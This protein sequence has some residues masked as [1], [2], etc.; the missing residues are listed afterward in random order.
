ML[1]KTKFYRCFVNIDIYFLI[2]LTASPT[3]FLPLSSLLLPT[4]LLL[5]L[6]LFH[7]LLSPL[8]FRP[9]YIHRSSLLLSAYRPLP[10]LCLS[11]I[12]FSSTFIYFFLFLLTTAKLSQCRWWNLS[13]I[14]LFHWNIKA[15]LRKLHCS[16]YHESWGN[17]SMSCVIYA[18][19]KNSAN[20]HS[21]RMLLSSEVWIEMLINTR[22]LNQLLLFVSLM[23]KVY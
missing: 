11:T 19:R 8:L 21:L 1:L 10:L 20:G 22:Y 4:Y 12:A 17:I 6:L 18:K 13:I 3:L 2:Y 23:K 9:Y 15:T 16:K 7:Y 5:L 14:G